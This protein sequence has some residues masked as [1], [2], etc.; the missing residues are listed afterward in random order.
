MEYCRVTMTGHFDHSKEL[1][2]Q[3][4][5]LNTTSD[6]LSR[7]S[8]EPGAHVVTPFFCQELGDWILVN[9]G[10]VPRKKVESETRKQGQVS[11]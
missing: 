4:R 9:R 11:G 8:S 10:S 2:V 7:K 6:P 3:P 5:S 1:Y